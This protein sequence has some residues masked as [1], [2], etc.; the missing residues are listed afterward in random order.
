MASFVVSSVLLVTV[1]TVLGGWALRKE[2][3]LRREAD[4]LRG[5][6]SMLETQTREERDARAHRL[7]A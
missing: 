4:E 2:R 6:E 1:V 3:A 7:G 5:L